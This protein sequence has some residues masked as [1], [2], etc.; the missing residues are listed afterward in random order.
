[1]LANAAYPPDCITSRVGLLI[2][3]GNRHA[4][5]ALLRHTVV[6]LRKAFDVIGKQ[7]PSGHDF[8]PLP[9]HDDL[10]ARRFR[11]RT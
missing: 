10:G 3:D 4:C 1:M 11:C 7:G 8:R 2:G 5:M 6:S 9:P